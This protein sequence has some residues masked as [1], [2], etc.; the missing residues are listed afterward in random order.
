MF[1]GLGFLAH[2]ATAGTTL[3]HAVLAWI[4]VNHRTPELTS[5]AIAV[6]TVGSPMGVAVMAVVGAGLS[7]W[8]RGSPRP[9]ILILTTLA[10]AGAVSTLSKI[11]VDAHRPSQAVQLAVETDPSF[12]SGHV[13]G[14]LALM[15]VVAVVIGH[16]G[17][18]AM[19]LVAIFLAGVVTAS[20]ALTRLYLGVHWVTDIAGGLL[21][22]GTAVVLAY[23]AHQRMMGLSDTDAQGGALALSG[24]A[25]AVGT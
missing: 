2:R 8:R 11:V 4:A 21:I 22:G 6:T 17:R 9:A 15:G 24:P 10:I 23:V 5:M 20:V 12:P 3:D 7:W 1:V 16:H 14:T 25:A 19:S 18:R 13:T